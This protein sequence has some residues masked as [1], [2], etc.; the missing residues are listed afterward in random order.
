MVTP[1]HRQPDRY[2]ITRKGSRY[3]LLGPNGRIFTKYQSASVAG[4]RWEELTHTPWPYDSTAYERGHRLW[5]LGLI[6]RTQIGQRNVVVKPAHKNSGNAGQKPGRGGRKVQL[7]PSVNPVRI[8]MAISP[9][10]LPTPT[11]DLA[12]HKRLMTA[13]RQNPAL[14]FTSPI[15]Q[16]LRHEVEYHRPQARWAAHLLKLLARYERRQRTRQSMKSDATLTIKHIK[17]QQERMDAGVAV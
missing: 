13:L 9:L 4:P 7:N 16:A 12:Q 2:R 14:L 15:Q 17:W 10:A 8:T 3:N 1:E 6:D 11:I 5:E